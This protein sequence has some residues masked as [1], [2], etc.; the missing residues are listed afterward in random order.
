MF[1]DM[2]SISMGRKLVTE[3]T[4]GAYKWEMGVLMKESYYRPKEEIEQLANLLN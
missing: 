2:T 4:E 1:V 3:M